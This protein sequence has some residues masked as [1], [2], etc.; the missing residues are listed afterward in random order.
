MDHLVLHT[1]APSNYSMQ[2]LMLWS[3]KS[4]QYTMECHSINWGFL[5]IPYHLLGLSEMLPALQAM[6]QK[7]KL[8]NIIGYMSTQNSVAL[9]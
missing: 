8:E 6:P 7:S 1:L 5:G 2:T 3:G 4:K 9:P